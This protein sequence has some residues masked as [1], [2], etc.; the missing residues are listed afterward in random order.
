LMGGREAERLLLD[1]ISIGAA[2]DL[3]RATQIARAMVEEF[4]FGDDE[5]GQVNYA[6][7]SHRND[8]RRSELSPAQRAAIDQSV[9]QLLTE[10]RERA[11]QVVREHQ[12]IVELLRDEL[13][14]KKVIDA[15]SLTELA[16][17]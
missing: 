9:R 3:E 17:R 16:Q 15:A 11:A 12:T 5:V 6:S 7:E 1:D 13:L 2:G 14:V 8:G 10:A 4:G